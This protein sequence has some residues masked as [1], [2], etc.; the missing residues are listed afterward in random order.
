[1]KHDLSIAL[2]IVIASV[3]V[4]LLIVCAAHA[5][6][7]VTPPPVVVQPAAPIVV[8]PA[9][10]AV[11]APAP[12]VVQPPQVYVQP[13]TVWVHEYRPGPFGL[14]MWG[15]WKRQQPVPQQSQPPTPGP[16]NPQY[17]QPYQQPAMP[18]PQQGAMR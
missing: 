7:V 14:L 12:V 8:Q 9:A 2:R 13:A 17:Q 1:M 6:T 5:Q 18:P 3:C 15:H 4:G 11:V 10:P 16:V